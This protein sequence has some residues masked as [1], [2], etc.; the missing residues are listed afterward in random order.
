MKKYLSLVLVLTMT[1][2]IVLAFG[3]CK[4]NPT[5]V[6][7]S[8]VRLETKDVISSWEIPEDDAQINIKHSYDK[9]AHTDTVSVEL[10]AEYPYGTYEAS[11]EDMVFQYDRASDNWEVL[12]WGYESDL[13]LSWNEKKLD[14]LCGSYSGDDWSLELK[15]IDLKSNKVSISGEAMQ[16]VDN[17]LFYSGAVYDWVPF[18][19][20]AELQNEPISIQFSSSAYEFFG[21]KPVL[22]FKINSGQSFYITA[23]KGLYTQTSHKTGNTIRIDYQLLT[24]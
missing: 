16:R 3:G 4:S 2:A 5:S 10:S 21:P 20:E 17:N 22:R 23:E 19:E 14:E 9:D 8:L 12:D 6:P 24:P 13:S 15:R 18:Q 11:I 1:L 7:D